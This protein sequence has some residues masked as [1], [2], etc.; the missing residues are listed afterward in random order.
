ML[1]EAFE[2]KADPSI[3]RIIFIATPHRGSDFAENPIGR[4]GSWLTRPPSPFQTFYHRI[5][6]ANPGVFTPEYAALGSGKLDGVSSLSPCQPTLHILTE[7]P[8]AHPVKVHSIIGT[9]GKAGPSIKV[10]M[11]S[12]LTPVAMFRVRILNTSSPQAIVLSGIL[13]LLLKFAAFSISDH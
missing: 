3:H 7:L 9:R 2:W 5:S 11:A 10:A 1:N 12:C 6:A 8:Y 13:K 4:I